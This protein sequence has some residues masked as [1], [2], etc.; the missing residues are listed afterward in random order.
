MY[1]ISIVLDQDKIPTELAESML[2]E[3][4]AWFAKYFQAGKFLI[5]GPYLDQEFAGVII[6]QTQSRAELDEILAEDVYFKDGQAAYEV[7]EFKDAMS[8]LHK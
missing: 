2:N 4:R 8:V 3:H 5:L 1:I 6:A 7:R